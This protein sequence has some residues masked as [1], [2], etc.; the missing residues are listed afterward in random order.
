MSKVEQ[1]YEGLF[2]LLM[3]AQFMIACNRDLSMFLRDA[4]VQA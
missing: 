2:D 1:T 4:S 3:R